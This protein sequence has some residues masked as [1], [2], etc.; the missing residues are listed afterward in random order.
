MAKERVQ[1]Q[2]LGGAVPGISPTI[3]RGGQYS[4]QVQQAGRNKLMDLADALG[5]VNPMLQQ[6]GQLQKQ[7]EQIGVERAALVEEQNVIDELKKQKD[8]DGFSVLATTNRDR[9]F[10]DALLKRHINN[11]MLPSLKAKA[12][13]LINA[14]TYRTQADHGK[15]VDDMLSAEWDNLIGQVGEG[16]ANSTAGKALW[17]L[18]STPYKNELALKYEEARDK[19]IVGQTMNEGQQLLDS[20]YST[21]EVISSSQIENVVLN[22]EDQLK[23]DNPALNNRERNKLLVDMIKTRAKT[24][25]ADRHFNDA[26]SLLRSVELIEINGNRIFN[27]DKALDELNPVRK[28]INNK[29]AS[30]KT[31][32]KT[33]LDKEWTGL[34]GGALKRL[35]SSMTYERFVNNPLSV[36]TVKDALLFMNPTLQDGEEEG[37]LDYIIKNE[38]FNKEVAPALALNDTLL[39]QAYSDPDRALPLYRRTLK[40]VGTFIAE[41]TGSLEREVNLYSPTVRAE[42]EKEF[43]EEHELKSAGGKEY[44][45]EEF[46]SEKQINA[47]PWS[48]ARRTSKE[49]NA[50]LFVRELTEFKNI[51]SALKEDITGVAQ[52]VVG[53]GKKI[54][55]VLPPKFDETHAT[56]SGPVIE[57]KILEYAKAVE[58][59]ETIPSPEKTSMVLKEL[60]RLQDEDKAIFKAVATITKE[61]VQEFERPTEVELEQAREDV[62]KE[63]ERFRPGEGLIK[64]LLK[65]PPSKYKSFTEGRPTFKTIN[66]DRQSLMASIKNKNTSFNE[67][68]RLTNLL[69]ASVYDHGFSSYSPES[70][71]VLKQ[72]GFDF[73]DVV[74]FGSKD[75]LDEVTLN[76][77]LTVID[78]IDGDQRQELTKED[79]ALLK[80]F[81]GFK[82]YD[83]ESFMQFRK[84][85]ITLMKDRDSR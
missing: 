48:S 32:S 31:E 75:E 37:Q 16:V 38:I 44:D 30:L 74:L 2:G 35:P 4:V 15:A 25:Q 63:K 85:Q 26:S 54:D 69:K 33:E 49:A 45:F 59:D 6:Y 1:V 60:R 80:E 7:Q 17:N 39:K 40:S 83:N 78:K 36:Q 23:E 55:E 65:E 22:I 3:Q 61:R 41:T 51:R 68:A 12:S 58:L 64:Q 81:G 79:K 73:G 5:Q 13:D 28:E 50:G 76:N 21:G 62:Q 84:A 67:Q 11:T 34:W 66:K 27:S 10:R 77:W 72:T 14:E 29:I 71:D 20:L 47:A 19:F 46:L 8:V 52:A 53:V 24:L 56:T 57:R 43:I 42:L 18:V 70:A 82:V 9:A